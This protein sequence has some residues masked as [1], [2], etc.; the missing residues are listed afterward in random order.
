MFSTL[1]SSHA[2]IFLL[3]WAGNQRRSVSSVSSPSPRLQLSSSLVCVCVCVSLKGS[4][5]A[6]LC[7][8]HY[9][10]FVT[11]SNSVAKQNDFDTQRRRSV[12]THNPA[13]VCVLQRCVCVCSCACRSD[14][15]KVLCTLW[16]MAG[17]SENVWAG[18]YFKSISEQLELA[19]SRVCARTHTRCE[20]N[21]RM[22][23]QRLYGSWNLSGCGGTKTWWFLH[24]ERRTSDTKSHSHSIC[25]SVCSQK[26]ATFRCHCAT[27]GCWL[28]CKLCCILILLHFFNISQQFFSRRNRFDWV[29][30]LCVYIY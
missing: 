16:Q 11:V 19:W 1:I 26:Y 17:L 29:C 20:S 28:G 18:F 22:R 24:G 10:D 9:Q 14:E 30:H 4:P 12:S 3:P 25:G 6:K 27:A 5:G 23:T 13:A 8:V 15:C 2:T 21:T 7:R